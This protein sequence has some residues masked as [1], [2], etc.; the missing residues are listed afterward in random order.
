MKTLLAL[1]AILTMCLFLTSTA[2]HQLIIR[3]YGPGS[4]YNSSEDLK[5]QDDLKNRKIAPFFIKAARATKFIY[6]GDAKFS[7]E[8]NDTLN[9]NQRHQ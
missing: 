1:L 6:T 8:R 7:F 4:M 3:D 5:W 2:Q 9:D